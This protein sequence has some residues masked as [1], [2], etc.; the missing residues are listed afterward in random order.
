M[1]H[2]LT[3]YICRSSGT[4]RVKFLEVAGCR[5]NIGGIESRDPI[6]LDSAQPSSSSRKPFLYWRMNKVPT[7]CSHSIYLTMTL[8]LCI[9]LIM[10]FLF[11][12]SHSIPLQLPIYFSV[13]F[14]TTSFQKARVI[15]IISISLVSH[16]PLD[17]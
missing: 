9:V 12:I 13:S 16:T 4:F 7:L 6:P 5:G 2:Q 15:S 1:T 3:E 10:C 17:R 8:I 14:Q 11:S